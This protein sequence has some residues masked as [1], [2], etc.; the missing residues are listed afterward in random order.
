MVLIAQISDNASVELHLYDP[1][2]DL[3]E[4]LITLAPGVDNSPMHVY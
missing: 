4:H 3:S 2:T 1:D